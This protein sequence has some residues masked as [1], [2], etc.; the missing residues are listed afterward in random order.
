MA[1]FGLLE[2]IGGGGA[3]VGTSF[4]IIRFLLNRHEEKIEKLEES[5]TKSHEELIKL[6]VRLDVVSEN[7][8]KQ[9]RSVQNFL[10]KFT[11][12]FFEFSVNLKSVVND[13]R[14][15]KS[16]MKFNVTRDECERLHKKRE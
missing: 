11:E 14:E 2:L 15:I 4:I 16:A 1:D 6:S 9:E 3:T 7:A 8:D 5:L 10:E 12:P 13:V